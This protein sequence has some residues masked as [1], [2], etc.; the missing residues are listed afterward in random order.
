VGAARHAAG[1]LWGLPSDGCPAHLGA[2]EGEGI[3]L[4]HTGSAKGKL[5]C[6]RLRARASTRGK[7]EGIGAADCCAR[8]APC[9]T[10]PGGQHHHLPRTRLGPS[11]SST[12]LE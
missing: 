10:G 8:T 6:D 7:S 4:R 3:G 2:E 12:R 9:H 1:V 11:R 5:K